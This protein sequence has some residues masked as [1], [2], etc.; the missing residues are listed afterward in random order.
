MKNPLKSEDR[1]DEMF[2]L[3]MFV[4]KLQSR[5][6]P[7]QRFLWS[8]PAAGEA[9]GDPQVTGGRLKSQLFTLMLADNSF[10]QLLQ[11]HLNASFRLQEAQSCS[12]RTTIQPNRPPNNKH[13]PRGCPLSPRSVYEVICYLWHIVEN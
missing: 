6:D 12:Q 2:H 13:P 10:T 9:S 7:E 3:V 4:F 5:A 8:T 1:V 11:T